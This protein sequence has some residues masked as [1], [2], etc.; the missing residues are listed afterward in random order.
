MLRLTA[1][2][3]VARALVCK[4]ANG[5]MRAIAL[6]LANE[7]RL[8]LES[9]PDSVC[10]ADTGRLDDLVNH[11]MATGQ[12]PVDEADLPAFFLDTLAVFTS[13][14]SPEEVMR[15]L[16]AQV[17]ET[18]GGMEAYC[19]RLSDHLSPKTTPASLATPRISSLPLP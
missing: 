13:K 17:V 5:D 18:F 11:F 8:D 7:P 6:I 9:V 16:M 15:K 3:V 1:R 14:D 12:L 10:P 2:A 4:A 19:D